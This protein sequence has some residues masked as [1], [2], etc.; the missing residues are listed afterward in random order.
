[1]TGRRIDTARR[2]LLRGDTPADVATAAGFCDQA[3][4][5]RHFKKHTSAT[6]ASYARSHTRRAG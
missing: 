2:L 3:H 5:T 1:M 4:L 6:P